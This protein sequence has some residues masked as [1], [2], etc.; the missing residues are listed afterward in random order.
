MDPFG[1]HEAACTRAGRLQRRA[2]PV[3]RAWVRVAR[4]AVGATGQVVVQQWLANTTASVRAHDR[5]R[6][7]MVVYGASARGDALCCDATVV[8]P[9]RRDGR[10]ISGAA[11]E[12]GVALRRARQRKRRRYP[13]LGRNGTSLVVLGCEVGGRWD[14]E[15]IRFV[16]RLRR[17]RSKQAPPLLQ[18]AVQAVFA[19]RWWAMLSVAVQK[20]LALLPFLGSLWAR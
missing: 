5:R 4:E 17:L 13:E 3:E 19:R 20:A 18:R 8:S 11:K 14:D 1:D 12:D 16:R 6:L 9:L 15:A 7:Y 10:A 2:K